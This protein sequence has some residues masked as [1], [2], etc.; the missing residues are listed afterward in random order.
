MSAAFDFRETSRDVLSAVIGSI[1]CCYTGQPF[2]TVKTRIQTAK[3]PTAG[4]LAIL[5]QTV[6]N[7]G[8][9]ALWKGAVPTAIG[10]M[11]ENA[12][13]FGISE[14]IKRAMSFHGVAKISADTNP[15]AAACQTFCV[16]GVTGLFSAVVLIPSEVIKSRTQIQRA[17]VSSSE[18]TRRIMSE[19]GM[20]GFFAGLDAQFARDA[21][22]YAAFFGSYDLLCRGL[23]S[24]APSCPDELVYF[25]SGGFA[26]MIGWAF[27]MPFDVP[28]TMVQSSWDSRVFGSY[29]PAMRQVFKTRGVLAL[30]AG[31]GPSLLRAFP[32]NAALFLGVETFK[33]QF[34]K[35]F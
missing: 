1:C 25:T 9:K 14:Q 17:E 24:M 3:S 32:A 19:R 29:I 6:A 28:K 33:T 23:K 34:D 5:Q 11:A 22:F 20:R 12:V 13:A 2:D 30:Y 7:E 26:G 18:I 35:Y 15:W 27:A 4:P 31:M 21:A 10:M 16:G 8:V